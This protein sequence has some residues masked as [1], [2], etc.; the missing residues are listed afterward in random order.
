VSQVDLQAQPICSALLH[1]RLE[2]R[3][4]RL[5]SLLGLV[6]GHVGGAQQVEAV[7]DL[8]AGG[9]PDADADTDLDL[10]EQHGPGQGHQQALRHGLRML[11]IGVGDEHDELVATEPAGSVVGTQL[12][13]HAPGDL[14]QQLVAHRMAQ[15]VVD[16][17]EVVDVQQQDAGRPGDPAVSTSDSR[18]LSRTRLARP[19]S[20]SC[21]AWWDRSSDSRR[22]SC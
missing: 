11:G 17:L 22:S 15:A 19:V 8:V 5:A 20:G 10:A 1:V 16:E 4:P 13:V 9:D 7:R 14:H 6:H 12:D 18:S 21:R 3:A 2:H